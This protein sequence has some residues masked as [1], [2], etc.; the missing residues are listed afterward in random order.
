MRL[1]WMALLLALSACVV[2]TRTQPITPVPAPQPSPAL[3]V[4][5]QI[6]LPACPGSRILQRDEERDGSSRVEFESADP[7]ERVYGFF[8]NELSA[9]GWQRTQLERKGPAT[10]IEADYVRGGVRIEF[11][12][13]QQRRSERYKLEIEF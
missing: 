11:K 9:R 13:D 1:V 7:L 5:A 4:N 8:H 3:T 12:L 6:G 2:T 10:K